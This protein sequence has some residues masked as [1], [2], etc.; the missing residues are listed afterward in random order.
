MKERK[1]CRDCKWFV[2][3]YL[4]YYCAAIGSKHG[5]V[6]PGRF[7]CNLFEM[8]QEDAEDYE[9]AQEALKHYRAGKGIPLRDIH[10]EMKARGEL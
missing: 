6:N 7:A 5:I 1:R 8:G 2:P 4:P 3:P 9:D 10:E